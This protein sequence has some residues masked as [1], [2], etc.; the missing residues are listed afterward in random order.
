[1]KRSAIIISIVISIFIRSCSSNSS[2]NNNLCY[3]FET[4]NYSIDISSDWAK[5]DGENATYFY[6]NDSN[7][8]MIANPEYD[9]DYYIPFSD[10]FIDEFVEGMCGE[11]D[12]I[13]KPQFEIVTLKNKIRGFEV[14]LKCNM[15][16]YDYHMQDFVFFNDGYLN[17]IGL[18]CE[19]D[20]TNDY[21]PT[22]KNTLETI[23]IT[24]EISPND[25]K[26]N[27]SDFQIIDYL[28]KQGFDFQ[29]D[30]S[31]SVHTTQ[32]IYVSSEENEILIQKIKNPLLGNMYT[33]CN[34]DVND[35]WAE[36]KNTYE[37][38]SMEEKQQYREYEKW[39]DYHG[40]SSSQVTDAL[41]YYHDNVT[42]YNQMPTTLEELESCA[43]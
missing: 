31:T 11:L 17:I 15:N 10:S 27:L 28:F 39:L 19:Y 21:L 18:L 41:D 16:G 8:I 34:Q 2:K 23:S 36:I 14:I 32:Y 3:N 38:D 25:Y 24:N 37:N 6:A 30:E 35:E 1:M 12:V 43:E 40:L 29:A 7:F 26:G 22:F 42:E 20:K 13:G 4:S 33:W 5:E 9:A